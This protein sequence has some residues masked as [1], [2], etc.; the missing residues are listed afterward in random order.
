MCPP[1]RKTGRVSLLCL[2]DLPNDVPHY[3]FILLVCALMPFVYTYYIIRSTY[4]RDL[5]N[6]AAF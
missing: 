3:S 4:V 5:W 1:D 6:D 2:A